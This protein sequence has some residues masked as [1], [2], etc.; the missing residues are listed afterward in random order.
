MQK[1]CGLWTFDNVAFLD[2]NTLLVAEDRGDSLHRQL[3]RMDSIWAFDVRKQNPP[4]TRMIALGRDSASE[5]DVQFGEAGTPG[6]QNE[7]DNEPSGLHV[8]DG[9]ASVSDMQGMGV[10]PE[11][12][13]VFFTQ[14]HG[15]NRIFEILIP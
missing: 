8:S 11:S 5:K 12:R 6:F 7:G 2:E 13:R 3:N 14:Q 15:L 9:A 10:N 1:D 4:G